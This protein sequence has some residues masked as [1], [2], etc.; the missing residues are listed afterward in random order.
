MAYFQQGR[1]ITISYPITVDGLT[2][3]V[4]EAGAGQDVLLCLHGVG[5]RADRF[6]P[7]MPGLVEAGFRVLAMDFPGHGLADKPED[8]GYRP[9]DFAGFV[10]GVLDE[11]DLQGVTILGTSLGGQVAAMVAC[12]RPELVSSLVLIGTMGIVPMD[13][14]AMVGPEKVSD[15]SPEAVAAKLKMVVSSPDQVVDAWIREE[16]QINSSSGARQALHKAATALNEDSVN[17]LQVDRL[18][19]RPELS[20]LLVWGESDRWTPLSMGYR[21]R[22]A[23]PQAELRVMNK[24][25][26]APYFENPTRF[27]EIV[28]EFISGE[29]TRGVPAATSSRGD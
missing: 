4:V 3:R 1:D 27:V 17:D 5:S 11:L 28:A 9:R 18:K 25:G 6:T 15:G 22:D 29:V 24:C 19:E 14:A 20:I 2:T 23:L 12:D 26:H 16:S 7:V 21:S 10:A 8:Y 13:E